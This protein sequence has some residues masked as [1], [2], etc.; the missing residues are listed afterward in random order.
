MRQVHLASYLTKERLA[1]L[2]RQVPLGRIAEP[3]EVAATVAFLAS[4]AASYV[5]G[6][7][8]DVHGGRMEYV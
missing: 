5:N 7:V 3:E 1:A 2:A 8:L 4:D 6:A